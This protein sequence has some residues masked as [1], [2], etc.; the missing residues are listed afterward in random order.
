MTQFDDVFAR[1]P[2]LRIFG[3]LGDR[4]WELRVRLDGRRFSQQHEVVLDTHQSHSAMRAYDEL[5]QKNGE[6]VAIL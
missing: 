2:A 5:A 6:S 3:A 4:R 1:A